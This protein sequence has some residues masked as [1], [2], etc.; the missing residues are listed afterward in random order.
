MNMNDIHSMDYIY[1][2]YKNKIPQLNE[3]Y[4]NLI[5]NLQPYQKTLINGK[6]IEDERGDRINERL[7]DAGLMS[8]QEKAE[9]KMMYFI[10]HY[11]DIYGS[12]KNGGNKKNKPK[13]YKNKIIQGKER[14]I[15]K[16]PGS[17]KDYI[18]Y[19]GAFIAVNDYIKLKNK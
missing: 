4:E 14:N 12:P 16:I 19:K 15:Y 11:Y 7:G 6:V 5:L 9:R 17:R 13:I 1:S 2:Y 18:K 8:E 3:D 10:Y